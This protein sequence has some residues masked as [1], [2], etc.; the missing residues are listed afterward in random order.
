MIL[1]STEKVLYI[2]K[3]LRKP[4]YSLSLTEI[5]EKLGVTKSGAL[6]ILKIMS[7]N[8]FVIRDIKTKRYSLGPALL[9][10]GNVYKELKG[11]VEIGRP[12]LKHLTDV[13]K[14]TS[15]IT[16]WEHDEAFIILKEDGSRGVLYKLEGDQVYG[17][18]IPIHCGASSKL[19]AAFQDEEFIHDLVDSMNLTSYGPNTIIDRDELKREFSRIRN[20]KYSISNE[21]Y[22]AGLVAMAVPIFDKNQQVW[23]AISVAGPKTRLD[24]E[25]SPQILELL[26]QGA[27]QIES[28]I[29]FRS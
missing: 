3:I 20:Q 8:A 23:C 16:I 19:L 27:H 10:L 22:S 12:I 25:N 13:T 28:R 18:E 14:E 15:Y 9:R 2:L 21:E 17:D 11:I 26:R 5:A 24:P 29:R 6:K 1:N 7:D 4:P